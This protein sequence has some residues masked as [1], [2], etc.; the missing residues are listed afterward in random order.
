MT[1]RHGRRA[2]SGVVLTAAV[3]LTMVA[4]QAPSDVTVPEPVPGSDQLLAI[5]VPLV[6]RQPAR[7]P[8]LEVVAAEQLSVDPEEQVL[9]IVTGEQGIPA[10][11]RA[12]Y[13]RAAELTTAADPRCGLT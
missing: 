4:A 9:P 13:E 7:E 6:P 8:S 11:V 10:T 2:L 12:A 1:V 3:I 5:V